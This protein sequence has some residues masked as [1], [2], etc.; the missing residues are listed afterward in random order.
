VLKKDY[1][2]LLQALRQFIG[3]SVNDSESYM[4]KIPKQ[5]KTKKER[6]EKKSKAQYLTKM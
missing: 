6:N 1:L 5:A 4:H 2:G 3:S